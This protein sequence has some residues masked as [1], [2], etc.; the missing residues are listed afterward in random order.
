M[1]IPTSYNS[2]QKWTD[3]GNPLGDPLSS[4]IRVDNPASPVTYNYCDGV[5]EE[6]TTVSVWIT[7]ITRNDYNDGN[8][9]TDFQQRIVV[10]ADTVLTENMDVNLALYLRQDASSGG[11][12]WYNASNQS[13]TIFAGEDH[14]ILSLIPI[15]LYTNFGGGL[16]QSD[17][18]SYIL[19]TQWQT[20]NCAPPPAE[21]TLEITGTTNTNPTFQGG[22]DGSIVVYVSGS[23]GTTNY[24]INNGTPQVS[25]TFSGLAAGFY[26][27]EAVEG[28]CFDTSGVTLQDGEFRTGD[29]N[30]SE[31]NEFLAAENPIITTLE[32]AI[33]SA[34]PEQA[35]TTF[36]F[37]SNVEDNY[38]VRF[39]LTSPTA[40]DVTFYAK[41]F[42]NKDSY[43]VT[44]T[45]RDRAGTDIGIN[46]IPE[47]A[48]SF[49]EAVQKDINLRRWYFIDVSTNVVTMTSKEEASSVTLTTSNVEILDETGA[50]A[51]TGITLANTQAGVDAYQGS[52][53]DK[54]SLYTD[55]YVGDGNLE[56]GDDLSGGTYNNY[57]DLEL[58]F[59]Q[60]NQHQFDVSEIL[61]TFVYTPKIDYNFTG[62]TRISTMLRPFLIKYGEKYPLVANENTKKKRSKGETGYKWVINSALQWEDAN[63][64]G[65]YFTG[66]TFL[67]NSPNPLDIQRQQTNFLYF[68]LPKDVG[69]TLTLEG[70][71]DYYDG[72]SQ[73]GITFINIATGTTNVGG[74][75]ILNVS[76]DTLG[77]EAYEASGNTKVKRC[78]FAIYS[79]GTIASEERTYRFEID[80]QPRKFG[81]S[82]LNK[83]GGFDTFDFVGVVENSINRD[84]KNYTIPRDLRS[85]GSSPEGFKNFATYDTK[86]TK[87]ITVN[88]GWIDEDHFDWLIELMHSNTIYSYSEPNQNYLNVSG[89]KYTKSSLDDLYELEVTLVHTIFENTISV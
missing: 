4:L 6:S 71:I 50:A 69:T 13:Y 75:Y 18:F 58:P 25:N 5:T 8:Q 84:N 56:Y 24:S 44:P 2:W 35:V 64:M 46:T 61:K 17:Q 48:E 32:T 40:Y 54:Y 55:V 79:G 39:N 26:D 86:V 47:V 59:S 67:T 27:V 82:F 80:E 31:P 65:A 14:R 41:D 57:T 23:T 21:C 9:H 62:F 63:D 16:Y 76:Y 88:S 42:P 68:V 1:S 49:A 85:D 37:D 10:S 83:L 51:T 52:L 45:L 22:S 77:L 38:S 3:A 89:Y 78:T 29:F 73:T 72:T 30:V 33:N 7:G 20:V 74:V 19:T 15:E 60:D 53:V 11:F 87:T 12:D 36:T 81:I 43:F 28:V 66:G 34:A 70:D